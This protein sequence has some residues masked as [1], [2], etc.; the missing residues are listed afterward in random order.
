M[1][2]SMFYENLA[3]TVKLMREA[4]KPENAKKIFPKGTQVSDVLSHLSADESFVK[5]ASLASIVIEH[6]MQ[7]DANLV[8]ISPDVVEACKALASGIPEDATLADVKMPTNEIWYLEKPLPRIS[9][10][11]TKEFN[12]FVLSYSSKERMWMFMGFQNTDTQRVLINQIVSMKLNDSI[13]T[14]KA[15][16]T[17]EL[18]H[19]VNEDQ[20]VPEL[21][22]Y[23]ITLE[24]SI[25]MFRFFMAVLVWRESKVVL[26]TSIPVERH[27]RKRVGL[28]KDKKYN[29]LL[30][31]KVQESVST[32]EG[33]RKIQYSTRW[34]VSG[35]FRRQFYPSEGKHKL[36]FISPYIKGP[37]GFEI[38]EHKQTLVRVSR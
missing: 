9:A 12:G 2:V 34:I 10:Y 26:E 20:N 31:R 37:E 5:G 35:H 1:N 27:T 32:N 30:L 24:N 15:N 8:Q 22:G 33:G 7:N 11:E 23:R 36:I 19:S 13:S 18:Y 16:L 6:A 14:L 25:R 38:K 29:Y 28:S 4:S 17:E 3:Y 21:D